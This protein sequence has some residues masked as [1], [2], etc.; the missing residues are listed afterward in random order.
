MDLSSD[1]P[2]GGSGDGGGGG[3]GCLNRIHFSQEKDYSQCLTTFFS[4]PGV[5][6]RREIRLFER[7]IAPV[8]GLCCS[9]CVYFARHVS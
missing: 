3:G 4:N 6:K 9:Q 7:L 5:N 2:G 8:G 1:R